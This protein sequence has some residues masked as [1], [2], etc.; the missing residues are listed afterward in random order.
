MAVNFSVEHTRT[1]EYLIP[2]E[3]I[4]IKPEL[5][6]RHDETDVEDLIASFVAEGQLQPVLIGRDGEK[7]VL[8]AGHRRW[9]AAIEINK[10]KLT[11]APFKL[12][13]VYFAGSEAQAFRATVRENHDRKDTTA[14]DDA[15]N[16]ARLECFGMTTAEIAQLYREKETWVKDRR[17]LADLG[18]A[19]TKAVREGRLKPTQAKKLARL[20]KDAQAK[21]VSGKEKVTGKEVREAEGKAPRAGLSDVKS[22]LLECRDDPAAGLPGDIH[23]RVCQQSSDDTISAFCAY[24]LELIEGKSPSDQLPL[25]GKGDAA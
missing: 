25:E 16:I 22:L 17:A 12:R 4:L 23:R 24:L 20:S 3:Q 8:Y 5:N 1:S 11:P 2:P 21:A 15:Y 6:G 19:A 18:A 9:M 14:I 10:R 13:C 7:P